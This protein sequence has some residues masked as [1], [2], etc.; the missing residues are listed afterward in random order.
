MLELE[1]FGIHFIPEAGENPRVA[2]FYYRSA[3]KRRAWT[4]NGPPALCS[5]ATWKPATSEHHRQSSRSILVFE[6]QHCFG[7]PARKAARTNT[8][9]KFNIA[10]EKWWLED[11]FPFGIAYF[12][13]YVKFQ[14]CTDYS[15]SEANWWKIQFV[16]QFLSRLNTMRDRNLHR[17]FQMY[18]SF[19]FIGFIV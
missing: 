11:E 6:I 16:A 15:L 8:P 14:G 9:P 12:R 7:E 13:G 10:P 17:T 18:F 3:I 5:F 2:L 4:C 1:I 19:W